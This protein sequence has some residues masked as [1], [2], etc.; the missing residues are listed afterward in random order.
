MAIVEFVFPQITKDPVLLKEASEKAPSLAF[1]AFTKAGVIRASQGMINLENGKDVTADV[2]ELVVLEWKDAADFHAFVKSKEFADY[3]VLM[4]PYMTGPPE[5]DLFETNTSSS[6]F[7]G[8]NFLEI[9]LIRPNKEED[10]EAIETTVKSSLEKAGETDTIY[11]TS[12]NLPKKVTTV[13]RSFSSADERAAAKQSHEGLVN[14]LSKLA[15]VTLL[16]S[17]NTQFI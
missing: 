13:I 6:L 16:Y 12:T 2:K 15:N 3:M 10:I 1:Q 4:K 11:G 8:R 9:L 5:L 17:E 14:E 7:T